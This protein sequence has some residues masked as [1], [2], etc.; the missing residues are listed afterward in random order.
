MESDNREIE[1][2]KVQLAGTSTFTVSLPKDWATEQGL[3]PGTLVHLYPHLDGS[4]VLRETV[5]NDATSR[6]IEVEVDALSPAAVG[7]LV[8]S[9][10]TGGF[11]QIVVTGDGRLSSDQ[12]RAVVDT[13]QGLVGG[14]ISDE[15]DDRVVL[16]TL[17]DAAGVSIVQT[18]LQLEFASLSLH[19]DA[20]TALFGAQPEE[21]R[22]IDE[23]AAD[24]ERLA[25]MVDRHC[26]RAL[27][28]LAELDELGLSRPALFEY[29][30]TA[31]QFDRVASCAT[32]IATA[33]KQLDEPLP[34]DVAP[35]VETLATD[36]RELVRTA[37]NVHLGGEP[38]E[39][40]F[41][42]MDDIDG[43]LE[44][45][46]QLHRTL[47]STGTATGYWLCPVLY[48]LADTA[49][50]ADAIAGV[51]IQAATRGGEL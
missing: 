41:E 24:V 23:R 21:R 11:D 44:R 25:H 49:R 47:A 18:M 31:G 32:A 34:D 36:V 30:R 27:T 43:S 50:A 6:Q 5:E 26:R 7:R 29:H 17:L 39:R 2:R 42:V 20:S 16:E 19:R 12:R 37:S 3:E 46:D 45:I 15:T 10:Y 14:N 1:T 35:T 51:A 9:L 28:D 13:A 48:G 33:A 38:V 4:L 22:S 40:A 8:R